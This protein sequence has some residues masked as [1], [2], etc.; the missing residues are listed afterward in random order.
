[1]KNKTI[2]PTVSLSEEQIA[3]YRENGYLVLDAIT[4]RDEVAMI[5]AVYDQL[6]VDRVGREDGNQFDL[7][8]A[9]EEGVE[10]TL[11]QILAPEKYAP[12]LQDT[13]YKANARAIARQL[14]GPEAAGEFGHAIRKPPGIGAPTPI[15]QDEAYWD[16]GLLHNGI[17]IWMPLQEAT[18]ENG[19]MHFVR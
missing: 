5:R 15:H 6:F 2:E 16:P 3:F 10:A 8:G 12:E 17:S 13:L 4:T 7:G 11:P 14:L 18:L 9:D 19:C 1:M